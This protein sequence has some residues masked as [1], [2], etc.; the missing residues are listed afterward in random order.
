MEVLKSG[1]FHEETAYEASLDKTI[2]AKEE[3]EQRR[4]EVKFLLSLTIAPARLL[5]QCL[6]GV[7]LPPRVVT[8]FELDSVIP[9]PDKIKE[10]RLR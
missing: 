3:V 6:S 9:P 8:E 5:Q 1:N 10:E 4:L 2:D 7:H